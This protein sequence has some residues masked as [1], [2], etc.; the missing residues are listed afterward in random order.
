MYRGISPGKVKR[1][2]H[3]LRE[4]EGE[5]ERERGVLQ[6]LVFE[7][8]GISTLEFKVERLLDKEGCQPAKSG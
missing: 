1:T 3:I 7:R 6:G 4:G 2:K 5:R 8:V